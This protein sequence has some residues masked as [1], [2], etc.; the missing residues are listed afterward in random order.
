MFNISYSS[1]FASGPL[2]TTGI[3]FF[4]PSWAT[5]VTPEIASYWILV[6]FLSR[7]PVAALKLGT[8]R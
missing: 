3:H 5:N 2:T 7:S 4:S 1:P 6:P 8:L